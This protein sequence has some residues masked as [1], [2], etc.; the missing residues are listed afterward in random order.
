MKDWAVGDRDAV[1]AEKLLVNRAATGPS[2]L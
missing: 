1:T 2:G